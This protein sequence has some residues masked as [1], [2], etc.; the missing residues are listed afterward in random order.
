MSISPSN[1]YALNR[2]VLDGAEKSILETI[3]MNSDHS[4]EI[5]FTVESP[6]PPPPDPDPEPEPPVIPATFNLQDFLANTLIS[7]CGVYAFLRRDV[8]LPSK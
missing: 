8:W 5:V 4:L 6:P 1:N 2:I 7:I 3:T